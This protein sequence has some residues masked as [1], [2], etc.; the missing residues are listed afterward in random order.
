MSSLYMVE[1]Y[2]VILFIRYIISYFVAFSAP[3]IEREFSGNVS[4][5]EPVAVSTETNSHE[6]A[7][8]GLVPSK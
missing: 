2:K 7:A 4:I 3:F 5:C 8:M 6:L 1:R